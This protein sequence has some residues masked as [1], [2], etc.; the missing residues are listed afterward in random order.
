MLNYLEESYNGS[1]TNMLSNS[2]YYCYT[3]Q[4]KQTGKFYSGSRGV[5]GSNQHDLLIKY[6]TSSTVIDFKDKC[7]KA[8]ELFEYR[9]EY[10]KTRRD[11]FAAET[12][13]H[14]KHNVGQ[15]PCFI[16]SKSSGGSNCGAG[17][18]LCKDSDGTMYRVSVEEFA[19]GN[20]VHISKG[21]MNIRTDSGMKK[22]FVEDFCPSIHTT[23]F[24]DYV[25]AFDTV[26][27]TTCRIPKSQFALDDRYVG[28]TKGL[29]VAYDTI[30][31]TRAS[32][33]K[34]EFDNSNGRYVG[35]TFGS[36]AVIDK[37]TGEKKLIEKS[38]YDRALYKHYNTGMCTVYSLSQRKNVQISQEEYHL[39]SH[40]YANL[41]T[42]VFYKVDGQ[43]FKS[44][45]LLNQ[46]YRAT[47]G[48]TVL[49]VSQ[50]KMSTTFN[51]IKT[52]TREEHENGKNQKDSN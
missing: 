32:I 25:V 1:L 19:T 24:K 14:Q 17:S 23:Q 43:F 44:K 50:Y 42:K 10:F 15:N 39:N 8:P 2:A 5:E 29:V 30:T 3:L 45:D 33:T 41:S 40:D 38:H 37:S 31:G 26:S 22:I 35:N 6:F 51:D 18:V 28:I 49:K 4:D 52:I 9:V 16:N 20:H 48:I 11:A 46:Y 34:E 13:F 7:K 12:V 27:C 36:V 47:R 21:M